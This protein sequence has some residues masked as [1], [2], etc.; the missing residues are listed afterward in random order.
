LT[1]GIRPTRPETGYGY[2]RLSNPVGTGGTLFGVEAFLE[3]PDAEKARRL[4]A[5]GCLWNSGMFMWRTDTVLDGIAAWLPD[6][7]SVLDRIGGRMG[8]RPVAEVLN[9]EYPRAPSI[10]IDFGLMEKAQNVVALKADFEWNDVGSWE[11]IRDAY[12]ADADG[13]VT[14]GDHVL[15]DGSNN[16]IVSRDRLVAILGV[17]DIVVVE[18]GGAILVCRRDRVQEVK[19]VV[20][21]LKKRGRDDLT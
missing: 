16:T 11:F 10:S 12:P 8:T 5:D 1:F 6:L 3:K 13:N 4:V 2:I 15:I 17:D 18:D 7:A 21:E 9:E 14:V 19:R 20:A